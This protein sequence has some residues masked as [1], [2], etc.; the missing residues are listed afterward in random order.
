MF[1]FAEEETQGTL[2]QPCW[3]RQGGDASCLTLI[4]DDFTLICLLWLQDL[5]LCPT[6]TAGGQRSPARSSRGALLFYSLTESCPLLLFWSGEEVCSL[7]GGRTKHSLVMPTVLPGLPAKSPT[8]AWAEL[9]VLQPGLAVRVVS[10]AVCI[11]FFFFLLPF[12]K[13]LCI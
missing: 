12:F 4:D 3:G 7:R 11:I 5:L 10:F 1:S 13:G 6:L 9:I 8:I 2:M